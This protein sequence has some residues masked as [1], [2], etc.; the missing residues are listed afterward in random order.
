MAASGE[1]RCFVD[2]IGQV[3]SGE[4][5]G[6][7]GDAAQIDILGERLAARVNF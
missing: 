2:G 1:Q 6:R 3:G 7:L 4:A 5:W